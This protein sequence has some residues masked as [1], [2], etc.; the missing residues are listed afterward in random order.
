MIRTI[1]VWKMMMIAKG[2]ILGLLILASIPVFIFGGAR[3]LLEGLQNGQIRQAAMGFI[4][5]IFFGVGALLFAPSKKYIPGKTFQAYRNKKFNTM[6]GINYGYA[7]IILSGVIIA[8]LAPETAM[9]TLY[10]GLGGIVCLYFYSR[11]LKFH[12]D[13]DFST[14]EYLETALGFPAG[15]KILVSY[16]NFDAGEIKNGCNAFAA[17]GTKLIVASFDGSV[18]RKLSRDLNQISRIGIAGDASQNHFVKLQFNDGADAL[19]R[20]EL[21]EKLTSNPTL[22]IRRLL[23]AIDASLLSDSGASQA[24]QRR[25]VVVNSETPTPVLKNVAPEATLVP[26]APLRNIEVAPDV[27][28]AIQAAEEVVPGRRLE[29]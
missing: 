21:Y 17:T 20:I 22:I 13:I 14:N 1:P 16:Q 15:E 24:V 2:K 23:E 12:E 3:V 9:T 8:V 28:I 27:L 7:F 29:L 11:T 10:Y 4:T 6:A 25:R 18:W 5:L 26:M 19:L